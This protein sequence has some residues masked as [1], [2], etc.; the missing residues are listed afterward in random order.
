MAHRTGNPPAELKRKV[1]QSKRAKAQ[2][3]DR[4]VNGKKSAYEL[5]TAEL[6]RRADRYAALQVNKPY[7]G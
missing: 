7:R 6:R 3:I 5:I 4:A 2:M 1:N